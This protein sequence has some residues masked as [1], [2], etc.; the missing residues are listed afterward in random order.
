MR[1]EKSSAEGRLPDF[2]VI[3]AMKAGTTTLFR[4]LE[5]HPD[6]FVSRPKEPEFFSVR[7]DEP[8]A[9]GWYRQLFASARS[10]QLC[11][12]CSTG[13]SRY[14]QHPQVPER[15]HATIPRARVIYVVRHP[16][17]R[18]WSHYRHRMDERVE[19]GLQPW[20]FDRAIEE[21][22]EILDTSDYAKQIE[23]YR[24]YYSG[25]QLHLVFLE[26]LDRSLAETLGG[27]FR[28]LDVTPRPPTRGRDANRAGD[29][30][31][32]RRIRSAEASLRGSKIG[33]IGRK[34]LSPEARRGLRR[35]WRRSVVLSR[36]AGHGARRAELD[37]VP[38]EATRAQ[39]LSH[40]ANTTAAFE[41]IANRLLPEWRT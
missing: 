19:A 35:R 22:P 27:V 40:F 3:G 23:R 38:P 11:G 31:G 12:E 26:D 32:Q 5:A 9:N 1:P 6:L 25:D 18:A 7:F 39:L 14:P 13:Y 28:F 2:V 8:G 36:L 24:P 15:M 4:Q 30:A 20:S 16:V 29:L 34:I 17:D 21:L 10:D 41:S 33:A 37:P